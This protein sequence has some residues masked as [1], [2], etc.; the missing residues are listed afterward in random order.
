M[1]R[2]IKDKKLNTGLVNHLT[3]RP[4][5]Q[6][7]GSSHILLPFSDFTGRLSVAR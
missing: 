3:P 1:S 5:P 7:Q 2:E 6:T 4:R